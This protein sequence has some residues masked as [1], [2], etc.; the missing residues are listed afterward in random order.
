MN[1]IKAISTLSFCLVLFLAS[2]QKTHVTDEKQS[3]P[4]NTYLTT[5]RFSAEPNITDAQIVE[6]VEK[7]SKAIIDQGYPQLTY[8]IWK[9]Y[10]D[11]PAKVQTY[12]VEGNWP[13]RAIWEKIHFDDKYKAVIE[14]TKDMKITT[15]GE[16]VHY[17]LLKDQLK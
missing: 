1:L 11:S 15:D 14:A 9:I 10:A 12:L 2:C 16:M 8:K 13:D 17:T 5:L 3:Q 7:Y 6:Y 4:Q